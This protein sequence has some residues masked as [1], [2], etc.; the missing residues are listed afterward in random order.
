MDDMN[1]RIAQYENKIVIMNQ[2]LERVNGNL[3]G[4]VEKG[5]QQ[6]NVI[7]NLT[8]ENEELKRNIVE[9]QQ[10][11]TQRYEVEATRNIRTLEQAVDSLQK[12]NQQLKKVLHEYEQN[13]NNQNA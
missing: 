8:R 10:T 7:R 4:Q 5:N 1:T 11:I 3:K 13:L 9:I 2:E 12:E 6:E